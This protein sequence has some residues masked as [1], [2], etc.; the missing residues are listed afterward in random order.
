[1]PK[2]RVLSERAC[3]E[4][5]KR[6]TLTGQATCLSQ[7]SRKW[8][9]HLA[10]RCQQ[11]VNFELHGRP[12][13]DHPSEDEL[14]SGFRSPMWL[15][16]EVKCRKCPM[17]LRSRAAEWRVRA[18]AEFAQANRTWLG[19]L[20]INPDWRYT[21]L[22]QA[23]RKAALQ[24]MDFDCLGPEEQFALR[25]AECARYIQLFLKRVRKNASGA[26]M[27]YMLVCEAHASGDPHYHLLIHELSPDC[28]IRQKVLTAAWSLGFSHFKLVNDVG[29]ATYA[30]KY[31]MKTAR[32]RVRASLSYGKEQRHKRSVES[33]FRETPPVA[34][35]AGGQLPA[36][37]KCST[38][39]VPT[40]ASKEETGEGN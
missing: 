17:C 19:T 16:M 38:E 4:I 25:D 23:R 1:M 31:L 3:E 11:P 27:R 13:V 34:L 28:P 20:T 40:Q 26:P 21:I 18:L 12:C 14:T 6:Y 32:T 15:L 33:R 36:P 22:S 37:V 2:L 29:G 10:G 7:S 8:A 35:P 39:R 9:L 24:G 5:V 30:T